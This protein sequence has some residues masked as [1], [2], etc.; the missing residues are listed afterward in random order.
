MTN[1]KDPLTGKG[2]VSKFSGAMIPSLGSRQPL[3]WDSADQVRGKSLRIIGG[4]QVRGR[5]DNLVSELVDVVFHS[6]QIGREG[7]DD[8]LVHACI[9]KAL[10]IVLGR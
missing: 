3:A 10:E 6:L 8:H 1:Q 9:L 4:L 7:P 2:F 5:R